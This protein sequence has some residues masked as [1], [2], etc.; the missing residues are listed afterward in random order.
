MKPTKAFQAKHYKEIVG[1][2]K[3]T[4][5]SV[6]YKRS[7]GYYYYSRTFKGKQYPVY[8]RRKGSMRAKEQVILDMNA[9]AKG[10]KFLGLGGVDVSDDGN[11]LAYSVDFTGFRQYTLHIKDLRTSRVLRDRR[12]KTVDLLWAGD[13][14]TVF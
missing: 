8:C 7:D 4:D 11:M 5:L 3:E 2:I 9:L 1:R 6:P 14:E 10:K 13:N 12:E